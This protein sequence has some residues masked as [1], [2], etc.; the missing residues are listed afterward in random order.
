M[1]VPAIGHVAQLTAAELADAAGCGAELVD[2]IESGEIAPTHETAERLANSVS[3]ALR[4]GPEALTGVPGHVAGS[5]TAISAVCATRSRPRPSSVPDSDWVRD[6]FAAAAVGVD[7]VEL[8]EWHEAWHECQ[9][10]PL[11]RYDAVYL[12]QHLAAAVRIAA[13]TAG[14]CSRHDFDAD[15]MRRFEEGLIRCEDALDGPLH[16][17][18]QL[19]AM[20]RQPR[21][22]IGR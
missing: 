22:I 13:Y 1:I 15:L 8:S 18:P 2:A 16:V 4:M 3:L 19:P 9:R 12:R 14:R 11:H 10:R 7:L 17:E 5:S 20:P 21:R 6:A